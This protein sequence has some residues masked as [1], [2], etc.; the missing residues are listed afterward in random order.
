M[1]NAQKYALVTGASSGIGW[2]ISEELAKQGYSVIAVSNQPEKLADLKIK[3]EHAYNIIIITFNIDLAQEYSAQQIFDYCEK[4]NFFVEVLVNNAGTLVFGEAVKV[5]Y[6]HTKSIL[7][8]HVTTPA[9]L[10]RLFGEQMIRRRNGFILNVSSISAVMPYPGISLYGP[11]KAF[12]RYFTRALRTELKRYDIKVTC[13]IPGATATGLYDHS[14]FNTPLK[15]MLGVMKKPETVAKAGVNALF[16]NRAEY[17]PG[18]LNKLIILLFPIVPSFIIGII[19][20]RTK[21]LPE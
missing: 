16:N 15:R 2:H 17:I 6:Y 8:L 5:D 18:V 10:C 9:L 14:K 11:T 7:N 20:K 13:L 19:Y 3:M 12:L 4:H 1:E 21:L